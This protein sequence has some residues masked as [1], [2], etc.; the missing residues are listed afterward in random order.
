MDHIT[1]IEGELRNIEGELYTASV[2]FKRLA[3]DAAQKRATYDVAYATEFLKIQ[4]NK[5][6]K[7]TVPAIESLAVQTVQTQLVACRIAEALADGSKRH[8]GTLQSLL[9]SIQTRASLIKTERSFGA[10]TA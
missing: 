2:E 9:S 8:L 7:L 10:Y 4:T 5:E 3:S 6:L 1:E